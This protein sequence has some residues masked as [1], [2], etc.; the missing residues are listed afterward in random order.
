MLLNIY[1]KCRDIKCIHWDFM[2]SMKFLFLAHLNI[3]A[4]EALTVKI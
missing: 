4:M 2:K 3:V 1:T